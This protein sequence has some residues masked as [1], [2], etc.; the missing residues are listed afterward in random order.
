MLGSRQR[1][2]KD[3]ALC[4]Y[5]VLAPFY[6]RFTHDHEYHHWLTRLEGWARAEGFTGHRV[7]DV[8][9]GT[10]KSFEPLLSKGYEVWACDLSPAMVQQARRRAHGRARVSVADMRSLPWRCEFDL[11]TCLD[12]AVNYLLFED[13]LR[14]A[15]RSMGRALRS[16]GVLIFDTNSLL[17][18]R[19]AFAQDTST[20]SGSIRFRW[21][22]EGRSD[23]EPGA[24]SAALLRIE[25]SRDVI[26]TRHRQRHWPTSVLRRACLDAGFAHVLFR[27]QFTGGRL[28]GTPDE[29][30][31]TKVLCLARKPRNS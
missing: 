4:A 29:L 21:K 23:A 17:T 18:Y 20:Q 8:A 24:T 26:E 2:A 15:L 30:R 31:H 25:T 7:L 14:A 11:V 28:A 13:D 16:A 6:D 19:T 5:E 10:G 12:D 22:G 9:C 27:G 1:V 3:P